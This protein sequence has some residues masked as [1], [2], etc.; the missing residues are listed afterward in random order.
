MSCQKYFAKLQ[1][2]KNTQ[3]KIKPIKIGKEPGTM[4]FGCKDYMQ[5]FR[6]QE[7]KMTNKVLREKSHCVVCRSNKSRFLK[8]KIN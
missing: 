4:C 3:S 6:P 8:Q 5:N 7:V 2:M 1:K